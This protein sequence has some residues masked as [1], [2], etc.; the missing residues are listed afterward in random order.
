M[1]TGT[2]ANLPARHVARSSRSIATRLESERRAGLRPRS[3]LPLNVSERRKF[4][5][6]QAEEA[7]TKVME[8]RVRFR[9]VLVP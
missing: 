2:V 7:F 9:A 8:N 6:H 4:A 3:E 1:T 5:L